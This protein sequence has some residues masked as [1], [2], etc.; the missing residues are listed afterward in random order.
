M[1]AILTLCSFQLQEN[2]P[3]MSKAMRMF[4]IK[5]DGR[6]KKSDLKRVIENF[7]FHITKDQFEKLVDQNFLNLSWHH[8]KCKILMLSQEQNYF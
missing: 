6:I 1:Y 3:K 8:K 2:G 7:A 4:D 5:L